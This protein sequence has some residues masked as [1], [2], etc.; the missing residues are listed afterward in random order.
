MAHSYRVIDLRPEANG[1]GEV[2]V[3][4]VSSPEAAVKKAFGLDL[5]RSGSKK[6]LMAQV[7]W[8]LSPEATNMVRLYARVESPRRR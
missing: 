2:V 7:Y 8:Q 4:G 6:D 3:D 1:A 5:V